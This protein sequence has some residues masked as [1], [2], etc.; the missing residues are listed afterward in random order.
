MSCPN[1]NTKS[2]WA[3]NTSYKVGDVVIPTAS[4][5][6][7]S[8]NG[9]WYQ[10]L[11]VSGAAPYTSHASTE[12]TWPA[13]DERTVVD[14]EITWKSWRGK[15]PYLSSVVG[16]HFKT[17]NYAIR[18]RSYVE[19]INFLNNRFE[20]QT[21][22]PVTCGPEGGSIGWLYCSFVGNQF[23][24]CGDDTTN[25]YCI[26]ENAATNPDFCIISHNTT[27]SSDGLTDVAGGSNV[28]SAEN[29]DY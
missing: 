21:R 12:P 11:S 8:S 10:V 24:Q 1:Y 7:V 23:I 4:S 25:F 20:Y 9:F 16:C 5:G 3:A 26:K 15:A 28:I 17:I 6:G 27:N 2:E 13:Y 18:S 19:N 29:I 14:N 22:S